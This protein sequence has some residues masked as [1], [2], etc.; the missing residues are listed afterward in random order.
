MKEKNKREQP[1]GPPSFKEL[2][3]FN[4]EVLFSYNYRAS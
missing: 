1:N 3:Y 2:L 4:P